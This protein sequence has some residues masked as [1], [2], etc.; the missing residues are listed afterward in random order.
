MNDYAKAIGADMGTLLMKAMETDFRR[1]F[2]KLSPDDHTEEHVENRAKDHV[3]D[4]KT[5]FPDGEMPVACQAAKT[6]AP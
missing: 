3:D 5:A 6:D 1:G 2:K 4:H